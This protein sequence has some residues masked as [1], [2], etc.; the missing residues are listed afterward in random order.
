MKNLT[1]SKLVRLLKPLGVPLCAGKASRW[2]GRKEI[3]YFISDKV[4]DF[5]SPE[6]ILYH[7][8]DHIP[9]S[10]G[11]KHACNQVAKGVLTKT[12]DFT[13][14]HGI[15]I[16][17]W[18]Q[19]LNDTWNQSAEVAAFKGVRSQKWQ[20]E[21]STS[22]AAGAEFIHSYWTD[23]WQERENAVQDSDI[24]QVLR[25][26]TPVAPWCLPEVL[27]TTEVFVRTCRKQ[28]G[29]AGPDGWHGA[30]I[31]HAPTDAIDTF[32]TLVGHWE[33]LGCTPAQMKQARL[34]TLGKPGK[35]RAGV[36]DVKDA[37][38]LSIYNVWW[39]LYQSARVADPNFQAWVTN[40]FPSNICGRSGF[41]VPRIIAD[42]LGEFQEKG[43]VMSLGWSKCFDTMSCKPSCNLMTDWGLQE[44]WANVCETVWMN[45]ER[46]V[47]W[48]GTTHDRPLRTS[49]RIPQGDPLGPIICILWTACG[50]QAVRRQ[51]SFAAS[52]QCHT[53]LYMDDRSVVAADPMHL[54]EHFHAWQTWSNEVGRVE[55]S[56]KTQIAV[57][58][59]RLWLPQQLQQY[60]KPTVRLL[61]AFTAMQPRQCCPDELLRLQSAKKVLNLLASVK[62]PLREHHSAAAMFATPKAN[63]GWISRRP[64]K[65]DMNTYWSVIRAGDRRCTMASRFIR[66]L[67]LGAN[68]ALSIQTLKM[69]LGAIIGNPD[70]SS[71]RW[72]IARGHPVTALRAALIDIGFTE[73]E[74]WKW[75]RFCEEELDLFSPV[76]NKNEVFHHLRQAWRAQ[77]FREFLRDGRH[78]AM[79]FRG[80]D[81]LWN[82]FQSLGHENNRDWAFSSWHARTI[83][84][85]AVVSPAWLYNA[86]GACDEVCPWCHAHASTAT[87][88]HM[89]WECDQRPSD[90]T[91]PDSL[92]LKR[93]GWKTKRSGHDISCDNLTKV[94][95]WLL[96]YP[97]TAAADGDP[98]SP[99]ADAVAG[100]AAAA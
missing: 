54:L 81:S 12:C 97:S 41:A 4:V 25:L 27:P 18:R 51:V 86:H 95:A 94:R 82:E 59:S 3:D 85:G 71:S 98:G 75:I 35:A 80:H 43:Y 46:W 99:A 68:S 64:T 49:R 53:A 40:S 83:A 100:A 70:R 72:S 96:R 37:R 90:L 39:R 21:L 76:V 93:F 29:A 61:G 23:F 52:R 13:K 14:P 32:R 44:C 31:C 42:L 19:V 17:Q 30:E 22:L 1:V 56:A 33:L 34:V 38:P 69:L 78:E 67:L 84:L 91:C 63:W 24:T 45:Q 50:H 5:D 47:Q 7:L 57:A 10:I 87:W 58:R 74:P 62:L 6:Q 79:E 26:D 60:L 55:N 89:C 20:G 2:K 92:F 36:L 77:Q 73:Q 16:Q 28:K 15:E 65:K 66:G 11:W 9:I 8:S 88:Y 48:N